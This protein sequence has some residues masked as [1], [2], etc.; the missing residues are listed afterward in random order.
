M[1]A[2]LVA[3]RLLSLEQRE[4]VLA[5]CWERFVKAPARERLREQSKAS[6]LEPG[7]KAAN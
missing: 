4:R 5:Y 7:M 3:M 1:L 6:R 2:V